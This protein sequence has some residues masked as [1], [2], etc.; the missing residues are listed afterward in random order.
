MPKDAYIIIRLQAKNCLVIAEQMEVKKN[1]LVFPQALCETSEP[2]VSFHGATIKTKSNQYNSNIF[3]K[4]N[5]T[6]RLYT[7][8]NDRV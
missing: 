2:A 4:K 3:I 6:A 1:L 8:N 5:V 7:L